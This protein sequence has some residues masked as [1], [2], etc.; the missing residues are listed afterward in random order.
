MPPLLYSYAICPVLILLK[1]VK[2][3]EKNVP[4]EKAPQKDGTWF[5]QENGYKERPQGS[6]S[7][8][9]KGQ[10]ATDILRD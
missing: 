7:Q 2:Q 6:R 1:E 9:S 3:N 8:K 5:P 4:T 10:K